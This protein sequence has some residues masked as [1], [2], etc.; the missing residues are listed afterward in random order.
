MNLRKN[1]IIHFFITFL[2]YQKLGRGRFPPSVQ[3]GEKM[4]G[5]KLEK[6]QLA[7]EEEYQLP[8]FILEE[9]KPTQI[10]RFTSII[11]KSVKLHKNNYISHYFHLLQSICKYTKSTLDSSNYDLLYI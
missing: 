7:G 6:D 5:E 3:Q 11:D 2:K 1:F 4:V 8:S 10:A 9:T